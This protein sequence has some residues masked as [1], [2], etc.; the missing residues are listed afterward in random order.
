MNWLRILDVNLNRLTESLKLLEDITRFSLED[1]KTL[2]KIRRLRKTFLLVKKKLPIDDIIS[3]RQSDKDL[4]RAQKFDISQ[5]RSDSDFI[6]ATITRAKESARTIEEVL[7]LENF[8][9]DNRI[10]EIRFSLYDIEKELIT[11]LHK[12]F[13]LKIYAIV[14]EQYICARSLKKTIKILID[15]GATILQLRAYNLSDREFYRYAEIIKKIV[16]SRKVKFLVNN[17]VDIAR[18]VGADGVHL[19]QNDLPLKKARA[20]I[21]DSAVIGVSAHN[22]KEALDAE[23]GGADYVGVGAIFR[24]PTKP[25][26]QHTGLR[27][28][29]RICK[30]LKIPVVA[31]GGINAKNFI[32]VLKAGAS[33]AAFCSFLFEGDLKANLRT[34]TSIKKWL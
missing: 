22:L 19:G 1:K 24:S 10:K 15:N 28:L 34:L 29:R 31:I 27:T 25:S 14:D 21:G 2:R 9:M 6:Y 23:K 18:A 26:A 13:D 8:A 12:K 17:R 5:R 16:D 30:R 3:S 20:I 11:H 33:G 32:Q 7:K 4:G